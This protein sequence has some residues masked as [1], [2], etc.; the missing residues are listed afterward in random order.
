[1]TLSWR[2]T[3]IVK[4][5][6]RRWVVQRQDARAADSLHDHREDAVARGLEI[7]RNAGGRLRVKDQT[8]RV[9]QEFSFDDKRVA[10][11]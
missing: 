9:E 2:N 10:S 5:R 8:G 3:W 6:G 7:S 4:R 1:M 11:F